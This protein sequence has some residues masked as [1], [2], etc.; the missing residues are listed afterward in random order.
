MELDKR[1][2]GDTEGAGIHLHC[3][4]LLP[5]KKNN[6]IIPVVTDFPL[7]TNRETLSKTKD[8]LSK[9]NWTNE[10]AGIRRERGGLGDSLGAIS[11]IKHSQGAFRGNPPVFLVPPVS[12]P[13]GFPDGSA[14]TPENLL[15]LSR[16]CE[17]EARGEREPQG[18]VYRAF[19]Q[20][21]YLRFPY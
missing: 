11:H 16:E 1:T 6:N 3:F 8:Y 17:N 14:E 5:K 15:V 9:W 19:P 12:L 2:S 18:M 4:S 10:Q 21:P 20:P 7:K 13:V